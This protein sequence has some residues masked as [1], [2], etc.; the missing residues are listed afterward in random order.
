MTP[1][2]ASRVACQPFLKKWRIFRVASPRAVFSSDHTLYLERFCSDIHREAS[3]T[4][5]RKKL[6]SSRKLLIVS[7]GCDIFT[8]WTA[9]LLSEH[10]VCFRL[11]V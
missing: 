5:S 7:L 2:A 8:R 10:F 11:V 1:C 9:L 4:V 6:K 3:T